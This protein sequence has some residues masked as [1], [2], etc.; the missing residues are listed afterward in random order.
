M[1]EQVLIPGAPRL[2]GLWDA[3]D[4]GIPVGGLVVAHPHPLH[5]GT[6]LQPVVYHLSR[7]VVGRGYATLRFNFRGVGDS[8]GSYD[9]LDE[10]RDVEAAVAYARERLGPGVPLALAGY[11]FG[12]MMSALA[13]GD[14]LAVDALVLVA[15]VVDAEE[16]MPTFYAPLATYAGPLL[17]VLGERDEMAPP[18]RVQEFLSGLGLHPQ[19][20]VVPGADHFFVGRHPELGAAVGDFLDEVLR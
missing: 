11:S 2:E 5:G 13:V 1:R 4:E 9:G 3:P 10:R 8:E 20:V 6:M 17:A 19:V 18:A 7:D 14:G 12:S 15:F 16:V